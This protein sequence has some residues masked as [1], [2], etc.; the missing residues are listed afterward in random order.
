MEESRL[1]ESIKYLLSSVKKLTD[2]F[3]AMEKRV[4]LSFENLAAD[5]DNLL[6]RI[7]LLE[8]RSIDLTD[9][10]PLTGRPP[11]TTEL[12]VNPE[13]KEQ[14]VPR[15]NL[16]L[17]GIL[18]VYATTPM[19]LEPFSRP[20]SVT[21]RT[22]SGE[23]DEVELEVFTQGTTWAV[24]SLEGAW[25]LVPRPGSLERRT[26]LETLERLYAIE[27]VKELP[28][29]LQLIEPAKAVVVQHGRR[30]QLSQKGRLSVN[31]DPLRVSMDERL[32]NLEDRLAKLEAF[33]G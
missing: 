27:G 2:S 13:M 25:L 6:E 9:C 24:E 4:T 26:Q 3:V 23:I 16:P 21:G 19:L 14:L 7:E 32:L 31:P 12:P 30:W 18:D 20:C 17:D 15:L 28:V 10:D 33:N 22:L 8:K 1:V 29:L 5:V 11:R